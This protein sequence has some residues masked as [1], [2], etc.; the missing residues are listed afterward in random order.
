MVSGRATYWFTSNHQES[1]HIMKTNQD[2]PHGIG[3][4]LYPGQLNLKKKMSTAD[5][6][7]FSYA[8][9]TYCTFNILKKWTSDRFIE[10]LTLIKNH[11]I[12]V[13]NIRK[14]Q[15]HNCLPKLKTSYGST[16]WLVWSPK[17]PDCPWLNVTI[18]TRYTQKSIL[19]HEAVESVGINRVI[20]YTE[21]NT[22]VPTLW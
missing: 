5:L 19:L 16:R 10:Q 21:G 22:I 8:S 9:K 11:Y 12:A 14:T 13:I 1:Q 20:R 2:R 17:E 6:V 4:L 7:L 18:Y 3:L 15:N